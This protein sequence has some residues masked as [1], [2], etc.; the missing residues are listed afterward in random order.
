VSERKRLDDQ[1]KDIYQQILQ[2]E[3]MAALDKPFPVS[4]TN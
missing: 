3:K 1:A 4:R 2:S